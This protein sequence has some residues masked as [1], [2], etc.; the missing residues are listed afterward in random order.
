MDLLS[1]IFQYIA[2]SLLFFFVFYLGF[3][4]LNKVTAG[5]VVD[6]LFAAGDI[7]KKVFTPNKKP[8]ER[9]ID[10]NENEVEQNIDNELENQVAQNL[11]QEQGIEVLDKKQEIKKE[12]VKDKIVGVADIADVV[13]GKMTSKLAKQ[14]IENLRNMDLNTLQEKGIHQATQEARANSGNSKGMSRNI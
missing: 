7:S 12:V 3:R 2:G 14:T 4:K 8:E 13:V 10:T 5:I 1:D 9:K 6:S 11:Y